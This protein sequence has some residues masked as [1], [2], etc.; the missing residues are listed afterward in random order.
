MKQNEIV[1]LF[2]F[3][4]LC[5]ACYDDEGN[6]DYKEI[7]ELKIS[8]I[9]DQYSVILGGK[10]IIDPV[11]EM[12]E[13]SSNDNSRFE[14]NWVVMLD[15]DKRD[16]VGRERKLDCILD[17]APKT[18][19]LWLKVTDRL[20]N[21]LWK[22]K[23][24]VTIGTPYTRGILL[25]GEGPGGNAEVQ[26]LSMIDKD[27]V[28]YGDVLRDCGLP[29]LSD[30]V[31][32][33]H[34]GKGQGDKTELW[35]M[36]KSGSY[37]MDRLT[38]KS[39]LHDRLQNSLL[40]PP[41]EEMIPIDI[42]PRVIDLSGTVA[43]SGYR[44][45]L[46]SNGTIYY[47]WVGLMGN[48]YGDPVTR[49]KG[50]EDILLKAKPFLFYSL[51]KLD[52]LIWYDSANERFMCAGSPV[53]STSSA[54]DDRPDDVFSW[55]QKASGRTLIYGEN[56][57]NIDGNSSN[58]NSFAILK[59][60]SDAF[61]YK[62]YATAKGDKRNSYTVSSIATGFSDAKFYAFSSARS[63]LFYVV[64]NS[65]YAYDYNPGNEKWYDL[66]LGAD[67]ITMLKFDTQMQPGADVLYIATY[68][69]QKGGI[70]RKYRLD[71]NPD[72]VKLI[73]DKNFEWSNLTKVV[74]MSW[75]AVQ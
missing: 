17:L 41:A 63:I 56:T 65:L 72:N 29:S 30:P 45:M 38:W 49:E 58:G 18:Y 73:Q 44:A 2:L 39:S 12:T 10:L 57:L 74:N 28:F 62:F 47:N 1:F 6:Y 66:D 23:T 31:N 36:T 60:G 51:K 21:V 24:S 13:G 70:L 55:N 37:Y 32:V 69:A 42:A 52:G 34:T 8:G 33:I 9:D 48:C 67:E 68:N 19:E 64:N 4:L 26:M 14:Y 20:T 71:S 54:L 5:M 53:V 43:N 16:T 3:G 15:N 22:K 40:M 11:I 7:N 59:N 27:T 75:R 25:I 50:K 61:I 35:V 46:C